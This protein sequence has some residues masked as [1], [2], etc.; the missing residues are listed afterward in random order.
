M[1]Q[2]VTRRQAIVTACQLTGCG[3]F[4][5]LAR[6]EDTPENRVRKS[7]RA[8]PATPGI[9]P[10]RWRRRVRKGKSFQVVEGLSEWNA[11][12][13][14]IIICD[15]WAE[16]PCRMAQ[17]RVGRIA[18]RMNEVV[19]LARDQGVAII[20]APSGGMQHYEDTPYRRR[21]QQAVYSE[22]P[23]PIQGWCYHNP[24]MEGEWPIVD[25]VKRGT[26]NVSGC[27]DPDPKPDRDHDRHEHP[28]IQIIGYD[29]ISDNG[30]EIHNFLQQEG[31]QNVVLMGVHTNMCVRGRPFGI[32]QQKYLG[33][34]VVL[35][36]DLTDAL[37]DPRDKP[38][39]SHARGVELV[40]EHI[41]KYWC[42]SIEGESLT[43]VI[44]G[45]AGPS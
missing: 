38:F 5:S 20:H 2:F 24:D 31:R 10:V 25:N 14:A 27:D 19:S 6:A 17:M 37:Y 43:K 45:T 3:V 23:M 39:V 11:S 22:P 26:S 34:N 18:P 30:Q 28:A 7:N 16:H 42:P 33:R 15:M 4:S 44:A 29:G 36:R 32:R 21:M 40:I 9:L 12:E 41:E 1:S 13:T 8:I 35:C